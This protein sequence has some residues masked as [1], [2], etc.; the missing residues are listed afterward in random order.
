[1]VILFGFF[2]KFV[3][4]NPFLV[5][6][7]HLANKVFWYRVFGH[8]ISPLS[9]SIQEKWKDLTCLR[10]NATGKGYSLRMGTGEQRRK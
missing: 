5:P 6:W 7:I 3:F 2:P 10:D 9:P 4:F 8:A 1:M